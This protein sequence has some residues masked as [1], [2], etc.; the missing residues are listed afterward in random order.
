MYAS[1]R[2][3]EVHSQCIYCMHVSVSI[4][5]LVEYL[6]LQACM[7]LGELLR[8]TLSACIYLLLYICIFYSIYVPAVRLSMGGDLLNARGFTL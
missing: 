1:G 5:E 2:A 7:C 8:S 4:T 6:H 3:V